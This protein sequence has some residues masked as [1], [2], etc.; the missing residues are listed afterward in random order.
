MTY[1]TRYERDAVVV[2]G[3]LAALPFLAGFLTGLTGARAVLYYSAGSLM[4]A[5]AL[6]YLGYRGVRRGVGWL[7]SQESGQGDAAQERRVE[8]R[9]ATPVEPRMETETETP[10]EQPSEE[11]VD[12]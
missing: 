6:A 12:G 5:V 10:A 1:L 3:T 9:E 4:L 7:L 8:P 11:V 2:V